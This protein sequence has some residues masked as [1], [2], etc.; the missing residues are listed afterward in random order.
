[1]KE[2]MQAIEARVKGSVMGYFA[3]AQKTGSEQLSLTL[4]S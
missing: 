4:A 2:I 1:M 3:I